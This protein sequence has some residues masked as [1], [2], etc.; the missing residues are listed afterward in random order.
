MGLNGVTSYV[1][2]D[3]NKWHGTPLQLHAWMQNASNDVSRVCLN[4]L[5]WTLLKAGGPTML[6]L[7]RDEKEKLVFP[8]L[9]VSIEVLQ[10]SRGRVRIGVDAPPEI[11]VLRHELYEERLKSGQIQATVKR[12]SH[13]LRNKMNSANLNLILAKKLFRRGAVERANRHC[14]WRSSRCMTSTRRLLL[15]LTAKSQPWLSKT[16]S[17]KVDCC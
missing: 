14:S 9:G 10:I 5:Q 6:V 16:T 17:T 2:N 13:D 7:S 8:N 4:Q 12:Y 3:R 15:S 1:Y 11:T